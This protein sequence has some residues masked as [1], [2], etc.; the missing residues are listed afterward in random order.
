MILWFYTSLGGIV[1]LT[2]GSDLGWFVTIHAGYCCWFRLWPHSGDS[3]V[4][5]SYELWGKAWSEWCQSFWHLRQALCLGTSKNSSGGCW[6]GR[7]GP[8][9]PFHLTMSPHP[10]A[11]LA[12]AHLVVAPPSN[13]FPTIFWHSLPGCFSLS[14]LPR[15]SKNWQEGYSLLGHFSL[16]QNGLVRN[17][18]SLLCHLKSPSSGGK[19][20][21][22]SMGHFPSWEEPVWCSD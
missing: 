10:L 20:R 19:G 5:V 22:S 21:H 9:S 8:R 1:L 18:T 11:S 13:P 16:Q 3:M 2:R 14:L 15:A 17:S 7:R 6:E 12:L 4:K